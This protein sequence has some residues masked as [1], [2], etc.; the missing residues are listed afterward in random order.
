VR[1]IHIETIVAYL[2]HPSCGFR[3]LEE[4]SSSLFQ[5]LQEVVKNYDYCLKAPASVGFTKEGYF[6]IIFG[7]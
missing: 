2:P 4:K 3:V 5:S 6:H 1:Q 7:G